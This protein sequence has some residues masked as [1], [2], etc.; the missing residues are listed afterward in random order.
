MR[1]NKSLAG[2]FI[3]LFMSAAL[4]LVLPIAASAKVLTIWPDQLRKWEDDDQVRQTNAYVR[5]LT[6]GPAILGANLDLPVG[7]VIR[8]IVYY[9][10]GYLSSQTQVILYRVK[11]GMEAESFSPGGI[12]GDV[13][14]NVIP[15]SMVFN[16]AVTIQAGYRYYVTAMVLNQNSYIH[17]IKIFYAPPAP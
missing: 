3:L 9:H 13:T 7:S 16:P 15:V 4:I 10:H 5:S 8:K 14:Q 11:M 2:R 6:T 17:G 1:L 12:S